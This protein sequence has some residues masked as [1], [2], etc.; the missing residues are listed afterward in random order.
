M[1]SSFS[2]AAN[3]LASMSSAKSISPFFSA[4]TI[5]SVLRYSRYSTPSMLGSWPQ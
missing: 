4:C 5:A 1:F 2:S 3:G